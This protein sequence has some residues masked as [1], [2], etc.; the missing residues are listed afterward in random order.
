MVKTPNGKIIVPENF[1]QLM[2][3]IPGIGQYKIIQEKKDLAV[4]FIVK[5]IG[6]CRNTSRIV[7]EEIKRIFVGDVQVEPI[8]VK[9][10][11]RDKSGKQRSVTSKVPVC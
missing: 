3:A 9:E 8:I 2:R 4:V 6:F 5:G 7:I 1:A 10:I 11:K